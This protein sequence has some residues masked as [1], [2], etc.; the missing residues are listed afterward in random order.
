MLLTMQKQWVT[1]I[2][3]SQSVSW[4]LG[5]IF[6]VHRFSC[7]GYEVEAFFSS[8]FSPHR[9][10][11]CSFLS[12][13]S[14]NVILL[15]NFPNGFIPSPVL[16]SKW[17]RLVPL[18]NAVHSFIKLV[19]MLTSDLQVLLDLISLLALA[20]YLGL[21]ILLNNCFMSRIKIDIETWVEML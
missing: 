16:C 8:C 17:M 13:H 5:R 12:K 19:C 4:T 18:G 15:Q 14:S 1:D 3:S 7:T 2:S 6:S 9:F 21:W 20:W 11:L 10:S